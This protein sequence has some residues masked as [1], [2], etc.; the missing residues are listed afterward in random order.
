MIRCN[1]RPVAKISDAP[2]KGMCE[3]PDFVEYLKSVYKNVGL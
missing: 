3:D 2:T 1:G